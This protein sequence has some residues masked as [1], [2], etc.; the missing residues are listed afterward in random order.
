M[1]G[2]RVRLVGGLPLVLLLLRLLL[3]LK[4]RADRRLEGRCRRP[5]LRLLLLLLL[6][7]LRP[8]GQLQMARGGEVN[9]DVR[10]VQEAR[11]AMQGV[12]KTTSNSGEHI[13]TSDCMHKSMQGATHV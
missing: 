6:G 11:C 12:P 7:L 10:R 1:Q 3:L 5:R 13:A 2:G 4:G 8:P 9:H